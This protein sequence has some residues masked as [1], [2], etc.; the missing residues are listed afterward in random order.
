M[1]LLLMV[2]LCLRVHLVE[3]A[4]SVCHPSLGQSCRD[5]LALLPQCSTSLVAQLNRFRHPS[6]R[7]LHLGV[8]HVVMTMN[9]KMVL[10]L[11]ELALSV[12][13]PSLGQSCRDRL[14]LLPQCSTSL[15]A[16][17]NR[18]RHPSLRLLHL[19]VHAVVMHHNVVMTMNDKMVLHLVELVLSVCHPSLGQSCRD[20]LAL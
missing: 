15:V 1:P 12:C 10:H 9:D 16:Q 13:H 20:R 5:R 2:H 4:L 3:L 18:F 17:L 11:V 19:V 14:A 6:L 8:V 7:L